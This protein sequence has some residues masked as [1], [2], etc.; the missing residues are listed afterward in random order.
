[1]PRLLENTVPNGVAN[2]NNET[3]PIREYTD[4]LTGLIAYTGGFDYT[5]YDIECIV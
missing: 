4:L 3:S 5:K 2:V 1:M